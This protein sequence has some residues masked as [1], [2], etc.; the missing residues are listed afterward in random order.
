MK[1]LRA[2]IAGSTAIAA[3]GLL[4]SG[5]HAGPIN[6]TLYYTTFNGGGQDVWRVTGSYT[7]NGTA[8]NGT[9]SLLNDTNIATTPGADG[10]VFNP[11]NGQL[12]V[13]GQGNAIYQ[14]NPG[15]GTYTSAVP[16]SSVYELTV[17]PNKQV[18]WGGGS[19]GGSNQISSTPINPF[20]GPGTAVTVSGSNSTITHITFAPNLPTGTAFYT[21]N[22]TFGTINLSTGVTSAIY[23]GTAYAHG[24]VYDAFTG[25]LILAGNGVLAQI[26]PVTHLVVSTLN[27]AGTFDQGAVDDSGHLFWADNS[28]NLL[29]VDFSTTSLIGSINNFVSDNFFKNQLDDIAPLSGVGSTPVPEPSTLTLLAAGLMGLGAFAARR[30]RRTA[31]A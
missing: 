6:D 28:G 27:A 8:G 1:L 13:G 15:S 4:G 26:D 10:L 7:G 18:V 3:I 20:G 14:V 17:D 22:G 12:L 2:F 16:G 21:S 23:S 29:F 31:R 30:R 11:N 24:M 19:E 25:D 5:A 9:F